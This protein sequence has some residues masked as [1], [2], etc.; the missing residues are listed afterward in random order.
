MRAPSSVT[1]ED[2]YI[3]LANFSRGLKGNKEFAFK[4]VPNPKTVSPT[5][6]LSHNSTILVLVHANQREC[7][8][9]TNIHPEN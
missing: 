8:T 1:Q 4:T 6:Y 5:A 9:K 2:A 3:F 7:K